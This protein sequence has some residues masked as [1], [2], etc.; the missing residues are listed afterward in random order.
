MG[1]DGSVAANEIYGGKT[2]RREDFQLEIDILPKCFVEAWSLS[3][4]SS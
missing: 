3:V 1:T 2:A 4:C